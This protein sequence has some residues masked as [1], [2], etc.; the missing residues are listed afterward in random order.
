[1][2]LAEVVRVGVLV[3]DFVVLHDLNLLFTLIKSEGLEII[4]ESFL[5]G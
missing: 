2:L 1:M 4:L 3:L 5:D